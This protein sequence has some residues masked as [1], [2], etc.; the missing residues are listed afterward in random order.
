[1]SLTKFAEGFCQKIIRNGLEEF[2]IK[3]F[4]DLNNKNNQFGN[5]KVIGDYVEVVIK[6]NLHNA[7]DVFSEQISQFSN[8]F[9][10]ETISSALHSKCIAG[11]NKEE[12]DLNEYC[13]LLSN[14]I[15]DD[16]IL[17]ISGDGSTEV[18][19]F[20][21]KFMEKIFV[22]VNQLLSKKNPFIEFSH[23]FVDR[24]LHSALYAE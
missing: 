19:K 16:A 11:K 12:K 15:I 18:E 22:E 13:N 21:H 24:C 9:V 7:I 23:N 8:N 14:C 20:S 3:S 4:N 2:E 6:N 5:H 10:H 1:M 17:L